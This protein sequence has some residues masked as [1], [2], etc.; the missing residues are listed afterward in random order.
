MWVTSPHSVVGCQHSLCKRPPCP[1]FSE[2]GQQGWGH[3]RGSLLHLRT[4]SLPSRG[5]ASPW[6]R[7]TACGHDGHL[8]CLWKRW[9][10]DSSSGIRPSRYRE[11]PDEPW[12]HQGYKAASQVPAEHELLP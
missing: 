8:H 12:C 4:F 7:A 6:L 11:E 1:A 2:E 9:W 5:S 10:V 3:G